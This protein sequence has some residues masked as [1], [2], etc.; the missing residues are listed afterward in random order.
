MDD[1]TTIILMIMIISMTYINKK[2]IDLSTKILRVLNKEK[3][4][5]EPSIFNNTL[6]NDPENQH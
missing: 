2:V 1:K 3:L 6:P 5:E 4:G